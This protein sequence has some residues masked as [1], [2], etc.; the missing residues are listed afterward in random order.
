MLAVLRNVSPDHLRILHAEFPGPRTGASRIPVAPV[1]LPALRELSISGS[2]EPRSLTASHILPVLE[3]LYIGAFM[4]A[5]EDFASALSVVCPKLTHLRVRV[6]WKQQ[7]LNDNLLHFVHAY[8]DLSRPLESMGPWDDPTNIEA[9]DDQSDDDDTPHAHHDAANPSLRRVIIEFPTLM[10]LSQNGRVPEGTTHVTRQIRAYRDV[11]ARA[12]RTRRIDE[13]GG[14][15]T[16]SL[17]LLPPPSLVRIERRR[18]HVVGRF[19][20]AKEEWLAMTVGNGRGY[21]S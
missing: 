21:W 6:A 12:K 16:K 1:P 20:K 2:F 14:N 9:E 10:L 15:G 13:D 11:A 8:C 19:S 4:V 17:V 3:K 5:E 7:P 18:E